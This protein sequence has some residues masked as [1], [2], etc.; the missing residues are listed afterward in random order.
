MR[1]IK[2]N[3]DVLENIR[4]RK[5]L[6]IKMLP[7]NDSDYCVCLARLSHSIGINVKPLEQKLISGFFSAM[8]KCQVQI[9]NL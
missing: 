1:K 6:D 7:N 9:V 4:F 8:K 2:N 5:Y 3:K